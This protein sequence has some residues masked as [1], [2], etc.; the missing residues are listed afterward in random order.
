VDIDRIERAQAC[1]RR[2][3]AGCSEAGASSLADELMHHLEMLLRVITSVRLMSGEL[4]DTE[5]VLTP[6]ARA[7]ARPSDAH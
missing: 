4:D 6:L 5:L 7:L 3:R 1:L 2:A